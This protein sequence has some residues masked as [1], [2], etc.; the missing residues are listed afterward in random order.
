VGVIC[1]LVWQGYL[2]AL[3]YVLGQTAAAPGD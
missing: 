3:E 2:L 1:G